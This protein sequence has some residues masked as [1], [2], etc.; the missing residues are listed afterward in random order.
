MEQTTFVRRS[1]AW[2]MAFIAF[3]LHIC[4]SDA[5]PA[6]ISRLEGYNVLDRR[7]P[8][9]SRG[10]QVLPGGCTGNDLDNVNTAIIDAGRLAGAGL[11]AAADFSARPFDYFFKEDPATANTVAGVFRRI[12][13]SGQ[14]NGR[15]I[16]LTCI[17]VY[18]RC[19]TG[20]AASYG[21]SAQVTNRAPVIVL[22]PKSLALPRVSPPCTQD[23]R[24]RSLG[25]RILHYMCYINSISG[26]MLRMYDEETVSSVDTARAVNV[27][28]KAGFDTTREAKAYS[29]LASWAW[30][31]GL[32]ASTEGH[33]RN[34]LDDFSKGDF[35]F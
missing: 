2:T 10:I 28:L 1:T 29:H 34:C 11:T 16:G 9:T 4:S 6:G 5:Q 19:E 7:R 26:P 35:D 33:Q 14:G 21:Y 15:L 25:A 3:A 12:Q 13:S 27:L 30:D 22:C 17:D 8:W 23:P 24:R 18:Q 31:L 32:G 20:D